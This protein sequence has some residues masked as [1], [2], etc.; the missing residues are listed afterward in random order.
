MTKPPA[1]ILAGGKATRM[2]G[3]DKGLRTIGGK[4]LLDHVLDRMRPQ[5]G[6]I[7]LNANGDP[8][9]FAGYGVP[10]LPDTLPDHPGPL[11]GVLAGLDWA[12]AQGHEAIVT[13]AADTPFFPADLVE[14][15]Q[16]DAGPSGLALAATREGDKVWRQPT[17]GLWPVALRDDLRAALENGLRKIVMWTDQHNAGLAIFDSN[18]V[19]PF[20]NINTPDD[21]TEAERLLEAL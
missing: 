15:L 8:E 13:A 16:Q 18:P 14:R 20:F 4:P 5:S 3:G 10:V 6:P 21:I 11:A 1:V 7:A 2:G 17:F 19:D 12:A 9:R